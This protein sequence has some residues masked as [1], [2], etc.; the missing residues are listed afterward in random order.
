MPKIPKVLIEIKGGSIQ[1]VVVNNPNIEVFIVN[2][3]N[4]NIEDQL[5]EEGKDLSMGFVEL[6]ENDELTDDFAE[7]YAKSEDKADKLIYKRL[8][9]IQDGK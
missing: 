9:E 8:K 4:Y 7:L 3:I 2:H 6:R 1:R 5:L